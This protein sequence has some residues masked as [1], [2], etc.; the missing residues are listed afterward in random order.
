MSR[1]YRVVVCRLLDAPMSVFA[2]ELV[3]DGSK[4]Q[5]VFYYLA[6]QGAMAHARKWLL[7]GWVS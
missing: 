3:A 7:S 4:V 2:L 5:A 1:D 6:R